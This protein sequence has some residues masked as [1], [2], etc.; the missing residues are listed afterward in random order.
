[1]ESDHSSDH[2]ILLNERIIYETKINI[3]FYSSLTSGYEALVATPHMFLRF[4]AM[5]I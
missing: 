3:F 2:S 5:R 1:M 4:L